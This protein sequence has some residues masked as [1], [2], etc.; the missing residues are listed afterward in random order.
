MNSFELFFYHFQTKEINSI[1]GQIIVCMNQNRNFEK[2]YNELQSICNN[3][4][5]NVDDIEEL[6]VSV[7]KTKFLH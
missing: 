2:H 5:E 1:L 3:V 4:I 6:L 7:K